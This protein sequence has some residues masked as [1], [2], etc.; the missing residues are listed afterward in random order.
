M[1]RF[2]DCFNIPAKEGPLLAS[3]TPSAEVRHGVNE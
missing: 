2:K 1:A 3:L